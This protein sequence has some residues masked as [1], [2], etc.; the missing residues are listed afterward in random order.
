[1]AVLLLIPAPPKCP[2]IPLVPCRMATASQHFPVNHLLQK[3]LIC[4]QEPKLPSQS[5]P[6][7][8]GN[9]GMTISIRS[10]RIESLRIGLSVVI[11]RKRVYLTGPK[12]S[13]LPAVFRSRNRWRWVLEA[14]GETLPYT[15]S[16]N[17]RKWHHLQH[18]YQ[19]N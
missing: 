8:E 18:C 5:V 15:S 4:K 12:S 2:Y 9:M 3:S 6:G 14:V 16:R 13:C 7:M 10:E 17:S 11:D 1:M 19:G